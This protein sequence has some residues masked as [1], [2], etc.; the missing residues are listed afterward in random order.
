MCI[1]DSLPDDALQLSDLIYRL[2]SGGAIGPY[3]YV[4]DYALEPGHY[5]K[6]GHNVV[7]VTL[8]RK[9]PDVDLEFSL[10]DVDLEIQY[11]PHR[12]FNARPVAY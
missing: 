6:R 1:R 4:Y 11:R 7:S 3:G 12:H 9:D 8:S 2:H 10:Y 5:P